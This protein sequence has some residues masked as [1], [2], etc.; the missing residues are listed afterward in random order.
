MSQ[1]IHYAESSLVSPFFFEFSLF[2]LTFFSKF[3]GHTRIEHEKLIDLYIYN[4]LD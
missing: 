1:S 3:Q 4:S 2:S